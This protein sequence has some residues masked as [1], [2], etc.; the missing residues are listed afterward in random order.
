MTH[1]KSGPSAEERWGL[2]STR[3]PQPNELKKDTKTG[4]SAQESDVAPAD[5]LTTIELLERSVD[6]FD[7][8]LNRA[9]KTAF[10]PG[11]AI[12]VVRDARWALATATGQPTGITPKFW[13]TPEASLAEL[14]TELE[15]HIALVIR[16][17]RMRNIWPFR[18]AH[19]QAIAMLGVSPKMF[20]KIIKPQKKGVKK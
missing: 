5:G 2:N 16:H 9:P 10:N 3:C 8:F 20:R 19:K 13:R 12:D 7:G 17:D 11:V 15:L 6:V 18:A 4:G 14:F 1:K